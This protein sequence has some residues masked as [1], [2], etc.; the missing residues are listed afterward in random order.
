MHGD[1]AVVDLATTTQPL[2]CGT[3]GVAAA[4]GRS[5]FIDAANCHRMTM[6]AGNQPLAVVAHAGLIP[7]DRFRETL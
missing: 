5:R 3:R 4:L 1:D 7:L 2:P 6:F